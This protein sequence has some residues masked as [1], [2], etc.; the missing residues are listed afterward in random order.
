MRTR[1]LNIRSLPSNHRV[2]EPLAV[3][4]G[5]SD[6]WQQLI[7]GGPL[8]NPILNGHLDLGSVRRNSSR[9]RELL[10][11][12]CPSVVANAEALSLDVSYFAASAFGHAPV[13]VEGPT[14]PR[15]CPDPARLKPFQIEVPV[16]WG[17]TKLSPELFPSRESEVSR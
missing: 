16:L 5:K 15:L 3:I 10:L 2:T 13:K 1:I 11:S 14:D 9:I 8:E 4:V 12:I 17:L 6:A 7:S